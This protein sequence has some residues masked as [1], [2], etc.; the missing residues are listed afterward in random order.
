M[1]PRVEGS[2]VPS[3]FRQAA[4]EETD[5]LEDST[6]GFCEV[7]DFQ[8]DEVGH[9]AMEKGAGIEHQD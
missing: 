7:L 8:S 2:G 9:G 3:Q 5:A 4:V 1:H 6:D